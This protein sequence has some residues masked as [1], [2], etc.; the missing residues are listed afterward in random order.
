MNLMK[1]VGLFGLML[2]AAALAGAQADYPGA[3]WNP[4]DATNQTTSN[5][6]ITYPLQYII[7]H[8]TEAIMVAIPPTTPSTESNR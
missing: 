1:T 7:I 3:T 5:R 8:V 4:A 6:P 2:G